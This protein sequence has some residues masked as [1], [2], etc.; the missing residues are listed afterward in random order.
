VCLGRVRDGGADAGGG[1][2]GIG[3]LRVDV[4]T[5]AQVEG[6]ARAVEGLGPGAT[7]AVL[8]GKHRSLAN[9][10]ASIQSYIGLEMS[11]RWTLAA[12][13]KLMVLLMVEG[14]WRDEHATY[15]GYV[16][17]MG[18]AFRRAQDVLFVVDGRTVETL[19]SEPALD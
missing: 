13:L 4:Q 14:A 7:R 19:A 10:F 11:R 5:A 9:Q 15:V 18:A 3:L 16:G 8:F 17:A 2:E 1:G 12:T 6:L